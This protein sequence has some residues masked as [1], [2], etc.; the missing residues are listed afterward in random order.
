MK[1]TNYL[2]LSLF[3]L[4]L[5]SCSSDDDG[6][7]DGGNS[8]NGNPQEASIVG[9]WNADNFIMNGIFAGDELTITFNGVA[10][11]MTGNDITFYQDNTTTG[12]SAPFMMDLTT[13][14]NGVPST[15]EQE[16]NTPMATEGTWSREGNKLYLVE[17]SMG[18][19]QEFTIETLTE[20]TLVI[21]GD[22]NSVTIEDG[23]PP[24]TEF[25]I[26][27]TYKR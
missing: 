24:N 3:V 2:F 4:G 8:G 25:D 13:I 5:V 22:H 9:S 14:I 26:K 27:L 20:T 1:I 15:T 19:T 10:D 21:T 6:S 12:N 7:P 16:M 23:F 11:T 18:Q 17:N